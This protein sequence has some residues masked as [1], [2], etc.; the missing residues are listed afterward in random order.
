MDA[1]DLYDLKWK[2][3]H[4]GMAIV[5]PQ[6][7]IVVYGVPKYDINPGTDNQ[8]DMKNCI[9][10]ASSKSLTVNRVALLKKQPQKPDATTQSIVIFSES[11]KEA[12]ACIIDGV[13]IEHRYYYS[14]RYLLQC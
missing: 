5:K 7:G 14:E 13:N 12:N 8:D 6:Y 9:E 4:K 11:A 10:N 1:E 2:K 3:A